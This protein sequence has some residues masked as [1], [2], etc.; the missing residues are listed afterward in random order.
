MGAVMNRILVAYATKH[1][2]THE[3]ADAIAATLRERGLVADVRDASSVR[4]VDGYDG[5]VLGGALYMGRWHADARHFLRRHSGALA[6]LPFAVFGMGPKT[7]A[8]DDV[9]ESRAQLERAL[10]HAPDLEPAA[11]AIFGGVVDPTQL[12]FPLSSMPASDA[13]DWDA[14]AAWAREQADLFAREPA[15][16][17]G[18]S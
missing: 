10:E 18:T 14:I 6:R 8:S 17:G 9:A 16:M 3:V 12:H 13:R 7:L 15:G 2:S 1:G 4:A 5:V 11:V